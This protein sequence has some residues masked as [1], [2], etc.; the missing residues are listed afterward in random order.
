MIENVKGLEFCGAAFSERT[1]FTFFP[2]ENDRMCLIYGKNGSGKSTI[3]RAFKK[4]ISPDVKDISYSRLYDFS[5]SATQI[6]EEDLSKKI[7]VF[8]EDY[9]RNKVSFRE[10]GLGTIAMF[11]KQVELE[12]L[13]DK[14]EADFKNA[15]KALEIAENNVSPYN[16]PNSVS[17]PEYYLNKMS[18]TLSGDDHWAGRERK[19]NGNRKNASVNKTTYQ[20]I[21]KNKPSKNKEE[22]CEEYR[23][24]YDTLCSARTGNS[25]INSK[26]DTSHL[27]FQNNEKEVLQLLK[28]KIEK[29]QLSEREKY[30]FSLLE[31]GKIAQLEDMR[32]KF[33]DHSTVECPFCLRPVS[34]DYKNSLVQSIEKVL[35]RAVENHKTELG[36]LRMAPVSI[37][38]SPFEKLDGS[39]L[40]Q[41]SYALNNLNEAI[42]RVNEAIERKIQNPY[43]P[44]DLK[45]ENIEE[46]VNELRTAL[47]KLETE[48]N[49]YNAPLQNINA[50]TKDLHNING[51]IA[52]YEIEDLY[53][54][55]LK[56]MSEKE[57]AESLLGQKS[58]CQKS[59]KDKLDSLQL[60]QSN[61][62]IAI[63]LINKELK[64]VFYSNNRL[65]VETNED[66]SAY[67]LK[68]NG[69][70]VKP[71]NISAGERNILALCYFFVEMLE[72]T[73]EGKEFANESLVIID[74]PISSFDH[75]NRIGI[76]S[77]LRRNSEKIL[78]SNKNSK[79]VLMTHDLQTAFDTRKVFDEIQTILK[80][81]GTTCKNNIYELKNKSLIEFRYKKRHEYSELITE[82]FEFA[83]GEN[84]ENES[85][86][87]NAMRRTL[88][89]FS[90]FVYKKGIEEIST[91][92]EIMQ[93]LKNEDKK[94]EEYFKS[95]MYRLVL[96]GES[97]SQERV[98]SL[99]DD[100]DF[101]EVLSLEEKQRTARDI[102]CFIFL[103]N[104]L[105][106]AAHLNDSHKTN[107]QSVIEGWCKNIIQFE[108]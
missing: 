68:T 53:S 105:H 35:S 75:E 62:K 80:N 103:L 98:R 26:V 19:I 27:D 101:F 70:N 44:I 93:F 89:A 43:A 11:G 95:L 65:T 94:Y 63:D 81:H 3:S 30:L 66:N 34:E 32:S 47:N 49:K 97:H 13:I 15:Q 96:N 60:Q 54:T 5:G 45:N 4:I 69:N 64:Y 24:K 108:S 23:I 29:P 10:N 31:E 57:K 18:K 22:L 61:V 6:S 74:D 52:Y 82:V 2:S 56:Q 33:S 83:N 79:M 78:I 77:L 21:I 104:P 40:K 58:K 48:R 99:M 14:A 102:I 17:S 100:N 46:K 38:L 91:C 12:T 85:T 37:D 84:L 36:R 73:D 42:N 76:M 106:V 16:D 71:S 51:Q 107:Y 88:E 25:I 41:C 1:A 39:I 9:I 8:N 7:F 50:V 55:Y 92:D 67:V 28:Q 90:T 59:A 72:D 86:I 87:G 20:S